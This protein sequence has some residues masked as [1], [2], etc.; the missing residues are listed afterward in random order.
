MVDLKNYICTVP[1]Q[2]LEIHE[3]KNFMCC[4]SWLTKELPNGVPLKELW[5]SKEAIEIRKSVV[6]G[7]Y[8]YWAKNGH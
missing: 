5:N 4:A 1:F 7:S 3:N 8:K 6:D 2:A